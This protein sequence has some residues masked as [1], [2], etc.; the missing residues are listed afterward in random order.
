MDTVKLEA[1]NIHELGGDRYAVETVL[2]AVGGSSGIETTQDV[3]MIVSLKDSQ[4]I[5]IDFA[6]SV[7][8]ARAG[9]TA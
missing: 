6:L 4:M 1:G 2:R 3:V 7:E 8:A 9:E 5:R